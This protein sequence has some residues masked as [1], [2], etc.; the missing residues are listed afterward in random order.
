MLISGDSLDKLKTLEDEARIEA[1]ERET[2]QVKL[3]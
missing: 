2:E 1:W 3:V